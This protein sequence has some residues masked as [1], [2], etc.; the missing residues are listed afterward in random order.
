MYIHTTRNTHVRPTKQSLKSVKTRIDII[1]QRAVN[2]DIEETVKS[3][4]LLMRG[5]TNYYRDIE[6]YKTL[7]NVQ[8][9]ALNRLRKYLRKRHTKSGLGYKEYDHEYM[10]NIGIKPIVTRR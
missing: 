9:Y 5:W 4:N 3:L 2:G 7:E 8:N 1:T 10:M 6:A